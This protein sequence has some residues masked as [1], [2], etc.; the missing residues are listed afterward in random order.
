MGVLLGDASGLFR[1]LER[2]R[3][4]GIINA[5]P[6][7]FSDGGTYPTAADAVRAGLA[8]HAAGADLVDVGGESTRPGASRV[9]PAEEARRV[10]P[11]VA[12]LARSGL[13]VSI[14]TTRVSVAAAALDAGAVLVNDVSGA[15]NPDLLELV[16][17]RGAPY[18]LMHSR[19]NSAVMDARAVYRD[20]VHEV[21]D[22]LAARLAVVTA[23]G[24]DEDK[25]V[26]DPGIGFAKTATH[27]WKLLAHLDCFTELGRPLLVGTSRKS[28]LGRLLSGSDGQPRPVEDREDATQATTALLAAAGVWAVRVHSVGPAVDAVRVVSAWR[29]ARSLA[30]P[31]SSRR[32]AL[33]PANGTTTATNGT[34]MP[35]NGTVT[36]GTATPA[37]GTVSTN[38]TAAGVANGAANGARAGTGAADPMDGHGS[39]G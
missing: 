27:N 26:V 37:N 34:A 39:D 4:M 24:I 18:V 29:A 8:M 14:D 36:N 20:V 35:T 33:A 21:A 31:A 17:A 1:P 10:V 16:A 9:D 5:T 11:V 25:V 6:D 28:F 2:T 32:P 7:S 15:A 30:A 38:G 23:A 13:T 22:E 3:V 19:G 12:E